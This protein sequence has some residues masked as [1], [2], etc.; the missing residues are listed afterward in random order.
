MHLNV[1][2]NLLK[3]LDGIK[4]LVIYYN[5]KGLTSDLQF[6]RYCD[7]DFIDDRKFFRS[8]YSYIFKFVEGPI[9]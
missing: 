8:T 3:F 4:E 1:G 6:I 5:Y 2:K 7:S 9:S